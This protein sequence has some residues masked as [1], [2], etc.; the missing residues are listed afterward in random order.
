MP[1]RP[2]LPVALLLLPM[3]ASGAWQPTVELDIG[4]DVASATIRFG[5]PQAPRVTVAG[6]VFE[7]ARVRTEG[8]H[9]N[10]G[11]ELQ[12]IELDP[13]TL[14]PLAPPHRAS[15]SATLAPFEASPQGF[16]AGPNDTL[17]S[18]TY[19]HDPRP[20]VPAH[21]CSV[22][23][24][25][26]DGARVWQ[27][28][29]P[30]FCQALDAGADLW[31]LLGGRLLRLDKATG[32]HLR[33][34]GPIPAE[35]R[36][37]PLAPG[38]G[39]FYWQASNSQ[40]DFRGRKVGYTDAAGQTQWIDT[41]PAG[42]ALGAVVPD[43]GGTLWALH[44]GTGAP[45]LLRRYDP[46]G[47]V[48]SRGGVVAGEESVLQA[49]AGE[50]VWNVD[51]G[52]NMP[53]RVVLH[54][55][56]ANVHEVL[57]P[58]GWPSASAIIEA[59]GVVAISATRP[60]ANRFR[61]LV[62]RWQRQQPSVTEL[63]E[64]DGSLQAA[65]LDSSGAAVLVGDH[66]GYATSLAMAQAQPSSWRRSLAGTRAVQ[67]DLASN[68]LGLVVY[69]RQ[70][71]YLDVAGQL[72]RRIDLVEPG[73]GYR[74]GHRLPDGGALLLVGTESVVRLRAD[75]SEA[76]RRSF[77]ISGRLAVNDLGEALV[78]AHPGITH[79]LRADGST[80]RSFQ[81]TVPSLYRGIG[82]EFFVSSSSGSGSVTRFGLAANVWTVGLEHSGSDPLVHDPASQLT[83]MAAQVPNQF[84]WRLAQIAADGALTLPGAQGVGV[85][86]ALQRCANGDLLIGARDG[87][88]RLSQRP[89]QPTS[90]YH[91]TT[92]I[93]GLECLADGSALAVLE[94]RADRHART[95]LLLR[96]DGQVR[97]RWRQPGNI[98]QPSGP[99]PLPLAL[100]ILPD[101]RVRWLGYGRLDDRPEAALS[102]T[103][104][105]DDFGH[106]DGFE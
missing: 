80:A 24:H 78:D 70:L 5:S 33:D 48:A 53:A 71:A 97:A 45:N 91:A 44:L 74:A 95:L 52:T 51:G 79:V 18:V 58:D 1:K 11:A 64:V 42:A 49:R 102:T 54:D 43:D 13:A 15:L 86:T 29:F 14:A 28:R 60:A 46:S 2:L 82:S 7:L 23:R 63:R 83:W 6:R 8:A 9:E 98:A 87:L 57:L 22:T 41:L 21:V 16:F 94:D 72:Q 81:L 66:A 27:A 34:L 103:L 4:N 76:W 62:L 36:L 30:S 50:V 17:V 56:A 68:G 73:L 69:P 59:D 105:T 19:E 65:A 75:G 67:V 47:P 26:L 96:P 84:S 38:G 31:L 77:A 32:T 35:F 20:L 55:A 106:A 101:G 3:V 88:T 100:R 61:T 93:H 39:G 10:D 104:A 85:A 89:G 99:Q 37:V 12:L 25:G 40:N 92:P 90:R